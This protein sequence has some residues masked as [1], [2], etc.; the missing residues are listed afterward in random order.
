MEEIVNKTTDAM[1]NTAEV[2]YSFWAGFEVARRK[3]PVTVDC[4]KDQHRTLRNQIIPDIPTHCL[5][6]SSRSRREYLNRDHL[7][8]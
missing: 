4:S 6:L 2:K 7:Q 1:K 8:A 5:R 3:G